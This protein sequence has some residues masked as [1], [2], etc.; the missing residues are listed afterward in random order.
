L[1]TDF[2]LVHYPILLKPLCFEDVFCFHLQVNRIKTQTLT[3]EFAYV[4]SQFL[5]INAFN[6]LG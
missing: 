4:A 5:K 1:K 3:V 2:G 6:K